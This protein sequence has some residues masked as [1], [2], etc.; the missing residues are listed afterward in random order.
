[1][2]LFVSYVLTINYYVPIAELNDV[3]QCV[4]I[5]FQPRSQSAANLSRLTYTVPDWSRSQVCKPLQLHAHKLQ[6]IVF[7][8]NSRACFDVFNAQVRFLHVKNINFISARYG[9]IG[10]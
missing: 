2:G 9:A 4:H 10:V 8:M 3:L 6:L 7:L 5:I 1:M